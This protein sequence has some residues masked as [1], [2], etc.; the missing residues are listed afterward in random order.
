MPT[1]AIVPPARARGLAF[2]GALV[3][4]AVDAERQ[5]GDDDQPGPAQVAGEGARVLQALRGRVAAA[6]DRRSSRRRAARSGRRRRAAS[7]GPRSRAAPPDSADRRAPARRAR[8]PRRP[9]GRRARRGWRRAGRRSSGGSAA[10]AAAAA[11]PTSGRRAAVE[12]SST[13]CGEPNSR[14]QAPRRRRG[15]PRACRRGAATRPARRGRSWRGPPRSERPGGG[16]AGRGGSR[17]DQGCENRSPGETGSSTDRIS[18]YD[19]RSNTRNTNS[20]PWR[21]SG[22]LI[23]V[24][25][26]AGLGR[27]DHDLALRDRA[28]ARGRARC[29]RSGRD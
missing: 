22:S 11:A 8:P 18:A 20:T 12:A 25:M 14:E 4:G 15:R 10:S 3:G 24:L 5:P 2:Q 23:R 19:M 21:S 7:A 1:T 29:R 16:R 17:R 27:V 13:P 26:R 9:D 28:P 6:D